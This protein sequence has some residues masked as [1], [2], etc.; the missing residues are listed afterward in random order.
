[1]S[2][3]RMCVAVSESR[4]FVSL[5]HYSMMASVIRGRIW[6]VQKMATALQGNGQH[7]RFRWSRRKRGVVHQGQK[8]LSQRE[9][10]PSLSA[11]GA[12][13]H[14]VNHSL[15]LY[16]STVHQAVTTRCLG[17]PGDLGV[18]A[19]GRQKGKLAAHIVHRHHIMSSSEHL[20][21]WHGILRHLEARFGQSQPASRGRQA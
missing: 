19:V 13:H 3:M 7:W 12:R 10:D 14:E 18:D 2:Q 5:S 20:Q 15:M 1:M 16:V 21:S 4:R 6:K 9:R 11:Y 17:W 8:D